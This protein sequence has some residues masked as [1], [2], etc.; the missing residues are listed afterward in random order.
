VPRLRTPAS[1]LQNREIVAKIRYGMEMQKVSHEE[2]ALAARMTKQTLYQRYKKPDQF[3]LS[4]L[5]KISD[6]LHIPLIEL[7][8]VSGSIS[9]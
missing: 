5:R 8:G 6:K 4:E 9:A 2:L 7:L 1:E 3:R